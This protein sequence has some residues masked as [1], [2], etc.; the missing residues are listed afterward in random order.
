M[1][2]PA[3]VLTLIRC[4]QNYWFDIDLTLVRVVTVGVADKIMIDLDTIFDPDRVEAAV[5]YRFY[6]LECGIGPD[7]LPGDWRVEWEER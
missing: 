5:Y 2:L 1:E 3:V 4:G 7:D 6:K